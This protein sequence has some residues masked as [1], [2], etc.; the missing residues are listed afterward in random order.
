MVRATASILILAA[1]AG[2]ALA[3]APAATAP[4]QLVQARLIAD[5][6]AAVPGASLGVGVTFTIA[7]GWHIY[8]R[9]PGDGGLATSVDWR[10]PEGYTA[11]ELTWPL[12]ER[13]VD[14][15]GQITTFG[16]EAK[17]LLWSKVQVPASAPVGQT[18][19]L[20]AK[21]AWLVCNKDR[22]VPGEAEVKLALPVAAEAKPDLHSDFLGLLVPE[23]GSA[24]HSRAQATISGHLAAGA[25]EGEFHL[26]IHWTGGLTGHFI[27]GSHAEGHFERPPAGLVAEVF[28]VAGPALAVT[29]VKITPI[30]LDANSEV[31]FRVRVLK[32][33]GP[34][35]N[36]LPIVLAYRD[37]VGVRHGVTFNVPLETKP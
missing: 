18:V 16:Y 21:A 7:P 30:G 12:P 2:A 10:L 23:D 35:P 24:P 25:G 3:D 22:C 6:S 33:A 20:T 19:T 26:L 11:G 14:P 15:S 28:P 37:D 8:W 4:D 31:T 32:G 34:Q 1:M 13:F 9:N 36:V 17:T 5:R 27:T 29:G